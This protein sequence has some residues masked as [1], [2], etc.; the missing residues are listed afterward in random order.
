[1]GAFAAAKGETP[2]QPP[3]GEDKPNQER[4]K[5]HQG[6]REK[7]KQEPERE[8]HWLPPSPWSSAAAMAARL[9]SETGSSMSA[10]SAKESS[11]V[12]KGR[13]GRRAMGLSSQGARRQRPQ[14]SDAPAAAVTALSDGSR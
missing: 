10:L 9:L 7:E 4:V 12:R 1:M 5:H 6:V 11:L 3:P 14:A 8:S 13:Q 2:N